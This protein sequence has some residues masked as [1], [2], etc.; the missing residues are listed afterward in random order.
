M[1]FVLLDDVEKHNRTLEVMLKKVCEDVGVTCRIALC[2]TNEE[3][4]RTYA[5]SKPPRTT[6]MLD[7]R[8]HEE[9]EGV[10]LCRAL[11]RDEERDFFIFVTAHSDYALECLK[12]HAYDMLV[13]PVMLDDLRSCVRGLKNELRHLGD[14]ASL[15]ISMGSRTMHL[16]ARDILYFSVQGRCVTAHLVNGMYT[17]RMTL[18]ELEGRL[19][20]CAEGCFIRVHRNYIVNRMRLGGWDGYEDTLQ[21]GGRRIPV[22]RR[23]KRKLAEREVEL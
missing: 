9:A 6:Y 23:M 4:V 16:M 8:L 17:W 11:K 5:A 18:N 10:E 13:K 22:S 20:E 19:E 1:T 14:E 15:K 2:T 12:L 7:I 21:V 3:D